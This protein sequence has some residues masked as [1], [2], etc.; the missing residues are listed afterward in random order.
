MK[1]T[2]SFLHPPGS[3]AKAK[4]PRSTRSFHYLQGHQGLDLFNRSVTRRYRRRMG[5][6][7]FLALSDM[8]IVRRHP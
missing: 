6:Q 7:P 3:L 8:H 1:R 5:R 4:F 2:L